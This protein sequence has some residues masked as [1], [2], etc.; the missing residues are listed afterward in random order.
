MFKQL[1]KIKSYEWIITITI[2]VMYF[3]NIKIWDGQNFLRKL[4]GLIIFV[5]L[6]IFILFKNKNSR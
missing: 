1:D 6:N 5:S 2:I 3:L 4:I